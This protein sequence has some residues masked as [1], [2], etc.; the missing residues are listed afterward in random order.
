MSARE[1]KTSRVTAQPAVRRFTL[2][3]SVPAGEPLLRVCLGHSP[4]L[5]IAA[6]EKFETSDPR[7]ADR[8]AALPLFHE[9]TEAPA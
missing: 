8:L 7:L 3:D 9:I 4:R 5:S 1:A 2:A 6:G